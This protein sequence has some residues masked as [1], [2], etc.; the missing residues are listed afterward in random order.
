MNN[1][2]DRAKLRM[3]ENEEMRKEKDEK[4]KEAQFLKF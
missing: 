3:Y 1:I 4:L 2:L